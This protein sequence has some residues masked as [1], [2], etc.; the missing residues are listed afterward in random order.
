MCSVA[1]S[2]LILFLYP[3]YPV[4]SPIWL[5]NGEDVDSLNEHQWH[6]REDSKDSDLGSSKKCAHS[7]SFETREWR[8]QCKSLLSSHNTKYVVLINA[9][10]DMYTMENVYTYTMG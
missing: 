1:P 6:Q 5:S 2:A 9:K 4:A 3:I 7:T 8:Q 10:E